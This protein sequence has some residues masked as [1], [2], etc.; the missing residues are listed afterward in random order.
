M[1][2]LNCVRKLCLGNQLW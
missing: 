1:M 2:L